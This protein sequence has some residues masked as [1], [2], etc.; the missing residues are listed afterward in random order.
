MITPTKRPV[1]CPPREDG[2]PR[3]LLSVRLSRDEYVWILKH[4]DVN[5]RRRAL[6]EAA[7]GNSDGE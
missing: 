1:G 5:S 2:R 6:L 3:F 4:T 7:E